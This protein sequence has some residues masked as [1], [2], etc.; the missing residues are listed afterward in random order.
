MV[1]GTNL[2]VGGETAAKGLDI[3][4]RALDES[5]AGLVIGHRLLRRAEKEAVMS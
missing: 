3:V 4:V 5:L 2:V 1:R